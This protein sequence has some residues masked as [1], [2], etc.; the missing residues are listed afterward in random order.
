MIAISNLSKGYQTRHGWK[1]VV[2]DVN[3]QLDTGQRWAILGRNGSGK[4][5]LVRLIGGAEDPTEG[6]VRAECSVSWPLAFGGGFQ[7]GLTGADNIAFIARIYGV[8]EKEALVRVQHFAELGEDIHEPVMNYSN[9]MRARLA[10]GLSVA[11]DF[12]YLLIDEI[13]SVGDQRFR[14]K[15]HAELHEKRKDRGFILVSH[16]VDYVRQY[17]T[18]AALIDNG[19]LDVMPSVQAAIDAY[20]SQ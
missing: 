17:C 20:C 2:Q 7:G 4:S 3:L 16:D 10:F 18:H 11:V 5:T 12:D 8:D 1:W 14:D 6:V 9:G 19:R 15:C 13:V